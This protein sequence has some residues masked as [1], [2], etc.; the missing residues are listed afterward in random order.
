M[1]PKN[2]RGFEVEVCV[3][4]GAVITDAAVLDVLAGDDDIPARNAA[5]PSAPPPRWLHRSAEPPDPLY[6][7]VRDPEDLATEEAPHPALEVEPGPPPRRTP[8]PP[9]RRPI[10][11]QPPPVPSRAPVPPRREAVASPPPAPTPRKP[12]ASDI[13]SRPPTKPSEPRALT[14]AAKN[15][16][17]NSPTLMPDYDDAEDATYVEPGLGALFP[18]SDSR[19]AGPTFEF[20]DIP[21]EEEAPKASAAESS[22]APR[23]VD[24]FYAPSHDPLVSSWERRRQRNRRNLIAL[25]IFTWVAIFAAVGFLG[26]MA[27]NRAQPTAR[28][29][30]HHPEPASL[31]AARPQ[32][33]A[34]VAPPTAPEPAPVA[35]A[36]APAPRPAPAVAP[37]PRP[38]PAP[39]GPSRRSLIDRGWS[40]V[41]SDPVAA[42]A[43]FDDALAL[44]PGD[45]EANYGYGYALIRQG[46]PPASRLYLCRALVGADVETQR[47]V[48]ALLTNN[49]LNC[50]GA[51]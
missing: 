4:C 10:L 5:T 26:W 33:E 20:N 13:P 27:W 49:G 18:A 23:P 1:A 6:T 8:P 41:E 2:I 46:N 24:R 28:P 44:R 31:R 43:A 22:T 19:Q 21:T 12:A 15:Y 34:E 3:R 45:A 11:S 39:R 32:P 37:A 30:V 51:P 25:A 9:R 50:D 42:A 14:P 7:G 29:A 16:R 35:P 48:N 47:E 36:A 17:V 38:A 40:L